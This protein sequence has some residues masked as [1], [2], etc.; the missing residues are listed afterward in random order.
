MLTERSLHV[1]SDTSHMRYVY[2]APATLHKQTQASL[3]MHPAGPNTL[4]PTVGICNSSS[5]FS[6]L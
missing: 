5:Y 2:R 6:A 1:V 4:G 3:S